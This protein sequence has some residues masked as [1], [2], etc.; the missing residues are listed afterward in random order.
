[1]INNWHL[2][3]GAVV[4]GKMLIGIDFDGTCVTHDY[5]RVGKDIGAAPVLQKIVRAGHDLV[6]CTMRGDT[7]GDLGDA[8]AWFSRNDIPLFCINCA[9]G[10]KEWTQSPKPYAHLY[11]DDTALGCPLTYDPANSNRPYVNWSEVERLLIK[12]RIIRDD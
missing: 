12:N 1:M 5:P 3:E 9:P 4:Y 11:I 7:K 8:I 2:E 6:L 10:Q